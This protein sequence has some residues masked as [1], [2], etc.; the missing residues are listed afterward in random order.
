MI[1]QSLL[2]GLFYILAAYRFVILVA[3]ILTW[4]PGA[5]NNSFCRVISSVA[6]VYMW[7]FHNWFVLGYIDFT[8]IIGLGI[9]E[10]I[11]NLLLIMI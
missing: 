11:I 7:P 1:L 8:P 9:L 10:G 3:I 2:I 5:R 4:I 6:D